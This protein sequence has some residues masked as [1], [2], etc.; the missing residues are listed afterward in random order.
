[1][2]PLK[3][4][5]KLIT[6][7]VFIGIEGVIG[8]KTIKELEEFYSEKLNTELQLLVFAIATF[9]RHYQNECVIVTEVY[10]T[11]E[12]RQKLYKPTSEYYNKV[13]AHERWEAVD[14]RAWN[15]TSETTEAVL[16]FFTKSNIP[17]FNGLLIRHTITSN[18][19]HFHIQVTKT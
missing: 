4:K 14:L 8:Y 2:I 9:I 17:R 11:K 16:K 12:E 5:M 6:S 1:M 7:G 18:V 3:D 13:G 10:R 15:L 19:I